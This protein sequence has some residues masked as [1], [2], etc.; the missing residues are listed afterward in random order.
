VE[1]QASSQPSK[2]SD[3]EC[4]VTRQQSAKLPTLFGEFRATV[5]A[6]GEGREHVLLQM[7]DITSGPPL[8]R[9]HSE[10]LTGDV[11]GSVR[12]DC[13]EQLITSL[14]RI[15]EEGRGILIYLRQEG[16]G[17]GLANKIHAYALQDEG[18]DTVDANLHLGFPADSRSFL[19][20]AEM[21]Q[22]VGVT[23]IRL[24]TNNP[25]KVA[26][27]ELGQ[28][29]VVERVFQRILPRPENQRYLQT[30]AEKLG[31]MLDELMQ[32][33]EESSDDRTK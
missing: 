28:I 8:V 18:L 17:I 9:I 22:D 32:R 26:D 1:E 33:A 10:C 23:Q 24:L 25:R 29:E 5:Y 27:L 14:N 13:R 11:L 21:L 16:R 31:H 4:L 7:G 12:C 19:I 15:A 20:A 2:E 3:K 30:K 6:D